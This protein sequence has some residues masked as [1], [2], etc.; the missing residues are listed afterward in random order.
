M[1]RPPRAAAE[2]ERLHPCPG[3]SADCRPRRSLSGRTMSI[4]RS[5]SGSIARCAPWPWSG[6]NWDFPP[7]WCKGAR[8]RLYSSLKNTESPIFQDASYARHSNEFAADLVDPERK[9][10]AASWF[11]ETTANAWRDLRGYEIAEHLGAANETWV[12][13][14]DGRYGLDSI[15]LRNRGA[16]NV[17]PTNLDTGFFK[18]PKP[19]ASFRTSARRMPSVFHLRIRASTTHFARRLIT[20][21]PGP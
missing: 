21:S 14:G 13:I 11:D 20:T 5:R 16:G 3:A 12:T 17:L 19:G 8:A 15:R 2:R 1:P 9:R 10:I 7:T 6:P 18:T 4:G